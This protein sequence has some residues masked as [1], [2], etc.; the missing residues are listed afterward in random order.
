MPGEGEIKMRALECF[1]TGDAGEGAAFQ[2]LTVIELG[3][4]SHCPLFL[5]ASLL[6]EQEWQDDCTNLL[7]DNTT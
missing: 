1:N 4:R 6:M 3:K 7:S 5:E 2:L